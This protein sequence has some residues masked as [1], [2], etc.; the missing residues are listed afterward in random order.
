M[1]YS[2]G[3]E[4]VTDARCTISATQ[5]GADSTIPA[6]NNRASVITMS[7]TMSDILEGGVYMKVASATGRKQQREPAEQG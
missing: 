2:P 7:L 5:R 1:S 3:S 4:P 6:I